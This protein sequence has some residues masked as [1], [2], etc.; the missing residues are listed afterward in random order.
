MLRTA[1]CFAVAAV[2]VSIGGRVMASRARFS[3]ADIARAKKAAEDN[4]L[5]LRGCEFHPDGTI[6]LEFG[7]F[8]ENDDWR[9]GTRY[10]RTA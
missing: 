7:E 10:Q 8:A 2:P 3:S 4:G 1:P 5:C 6:K 9:A